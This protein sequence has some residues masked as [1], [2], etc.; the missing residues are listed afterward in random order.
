MSKPQHE[1]SN[2]V[3]SVVSDLVVNGFNDKSIERIGGALVLAGTK[4]VIA[5]IRGDENASRVMS[6]AGD[7]A[8][9]S[10][11]ATTAVLESIGAG[12]LGL[13]AAPMGVLSLAVVQ[14]E[15]AV[16]LKRVTNIE[17]RLQETQALL[18][19]VNRKLDLGF[20]SNFCAALDLASR[21]F[22]MEKEK[23]RSDAAWQAVNRL[24]EA[25]RHY[26]KLADYEISAKSRL[27]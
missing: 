22:T 21:A 13:G 11:K 23:N 2:I 12:A 16:L 3:C 8:G 7:A 19:Q 6:I 25:R 26:T 15:F 24:A 4:K 27:A 17:R 9:S 1:N 5:L 10:S 20:Y 18:E 14:M